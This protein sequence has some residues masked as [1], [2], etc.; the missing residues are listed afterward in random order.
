LRFIQKIEIVDYETNAER[1]ATDRPKKR[2]AVRPPLVAA[3][4][5]YMGG[6]GT[7]RIGEDLGVYQSLLPAIKKIGRSFR[8]ANLFCR[9][10][11]HID[12]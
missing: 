12:I 9:D 1:A 6:T 10:N 5:G 7:P 2:G 11:R 4:R 3:C 8:S